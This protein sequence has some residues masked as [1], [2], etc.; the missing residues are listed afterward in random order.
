MGYRSRV[1]RCSCGD[2]G[3]VSQAVLGLGGQLLW[4][5]SISSAHGAC[6]VALDRALV[7]RC[8][9]SE[10]GFFSG[11]CQLWPCFTGSACWQMSPMKTDRSDFT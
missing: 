5:Q 1:E 7:L 6:C 10:S 9:G 3:R 11:S 4:G 8:T 2:L